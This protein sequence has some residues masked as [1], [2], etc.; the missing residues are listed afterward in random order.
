MIDIDINSD[1]AFI[2][3]SSD[4]VSI[5]RIGDVITLTKKTSNTDL[6]IARDP[7]KF[8]F[9][10]DKLDSLGGTFSSI[11]YADVIRLSTTG[12]YKLD[13]LV[14]AHSQKGCMSIL[15]GGLIYSLAYISDCYI[16]GYSRNIDKIIIDFS[17]G[18]CEMIYDR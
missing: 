1:E 2:Y 6:E 10:A 17:V 13:N 16:S 5:N 9:K 15:Q 18:K 7:W 8:L 12:P 3:Y 14:Y 4:P 11:H